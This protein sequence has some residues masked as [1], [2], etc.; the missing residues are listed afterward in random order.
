MNTAL[1]RLATVVVVMFL[2]LLA[3]TTWVQFGQASALNNDSRNVRTLYREYGK[4]RGPIIVAGQ[5]VAQSTA[6]DDPFGFQRAYTQPELYSTVTGFYSVVNG[7]S[8]L[9]RSMNDVLTGQADSLFWT[10]IQDLVT[11]AQPQ[12]SSIELTIDPAA[13]QAALDALGGQQG[14]VVA[15]EPAT[16]KI[17]AMVSTPGFDPNALAT[18]DTTAANA[19]Y[20]QLLA[21]DGDPLINK[22]T[23]EN[24]PPGSTFKLVTAAAA[25]ESGAYT[26]ESVLSAPDL[27][28]L[29]GTRTTLPNFGGSS[30]GANQQTTLADALRIS[31]NTAFASLG[32]ELGDDAIR[33]QAEKFGFDQTDLTVPMRVAASRYP[34]DLDD[35]QTALSAIGQESVRATP[36][37][38]AMVASA[39][40]NGG[41]L[42]TPYLVQTVRTANLDVVSEADPTELSQAVSAATAQQLT[43]MMIGVVQSGSGTS[44]QISGVQVAG[45]TGT[46]QTGVEGDSPHAWFTGFAPA[47]DPQVAVAVIV[48]HG[49]SV[50][51]EATGGRVAAPIAKAVME[52]VIN[53]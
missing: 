44:A 31:C 26:P 17:L 21:A 16:G 52:A 23:S 19:A 40:A 30:C 11:G 49:G 9:E 18:H 47:D 25:L 48:E 22:T 38:M 41:T 10:R 28:T 2:A 45:K 14:A 29:P 32:V 51:S 36:T 24:Y 39:I 34:E 27:Y 15:V 20:Q 7:G 46:A 1:R 12:G 43:D 8:Q 37:Q 33:E 6:V 50:G 13:Q 5:P 4:P 35:A 3:G 42:M 53:P